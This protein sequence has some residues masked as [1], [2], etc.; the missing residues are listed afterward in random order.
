MADL[1]MQHS[2]HQL[3]QPSPCL[4]QG[5]GQI[6]N[7]D[8]AFNLCR[9]VYPLPLNASTTEPMAAMPL[10]SGRLL[11]AE[12][13]W[14]DPP[15]PRHRESHLQEQTMHWGPLGPP[16]DRMYS[17][18]ARFGYDRIAYHTGMNH[19]LY[20]PSGRD[21]DAR[22][23]TYSSRYLLPPPFIHRYMDYPHDSAMHLQHGAMGHGSYVDPPHPFRSPHM[24]DGHPSSSHDLP[25]GPYQPGHSSTLINAGA[26]PSIPDDM[27]RS[28]APHID[29]TLDVSKPAEN[30]AGE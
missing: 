7:L 14:V 1:P 11:D 18:D 22:Y 21:Q 3:V 20:D 13:G 26:S 9:R 15:P 29:A 16:P 30:M 8:E 17:G 4:V 23:G 10:S 25:A 5:A 27:Q 6:N 2:S 19:P 24:A 28:T 12:E